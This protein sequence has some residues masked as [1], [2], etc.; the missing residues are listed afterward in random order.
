MENERRVTLLFQP[1]FYNKVERMCKARDERKDDHGRKKFL[2]MDSDGQLL[3]KI[4]DE[5]TEK[6]STSYS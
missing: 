2:S 6:F 1:Y 4:I 5:Q 3:L